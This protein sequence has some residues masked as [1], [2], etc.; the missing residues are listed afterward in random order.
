MKTVRFQKG[1]SSR[2]R[3]PKISAVDENNNNKYKKSYGPSKEETTREQMKEFGLNGCTGCLSREH[4]YERFKTCGNTCPFCDKE[5]RKNDD[6]HFAFNCNKRPQD[7]RECI[8]ILMEK[9][10]KR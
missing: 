10:R 4:S 9:E 1:N 8:Q 5:F 2:E 3:S 6:R 7:R